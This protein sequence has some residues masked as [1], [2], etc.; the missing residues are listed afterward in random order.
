M[1]IVI[2]ESVVETI[3]VIKAVLKMR[4][5][6]GC[7]EGVRSMPGVISICRRAVLSLGRTAFTMG[8]V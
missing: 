4:T 1:L 8:T 6:V 3:V 7:G 2:V 5:R